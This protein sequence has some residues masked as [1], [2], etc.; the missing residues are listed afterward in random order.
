MFESNVPRFTSPSISLVRWMV[1]LRPIT[2]KTV[3]QDKPEWSVEIKFLLRWPKHLFPVGLKSMI[4]FFTFCKEKL[5]IEI[6]EAN[7]HSCR[8][9]NK[10]GMTCKLQWADW[11]FCSL[12]RQFLFVCTSLFLPFYLLEPGQHLFSHGER[13]VSSVVGNRVEREGFWCDTEMGT[14]CKH[15]KR[16]FPPGKSGLV[17]TGCQNIFKRGVLLALV[18]LL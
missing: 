1:K 9:L 10:R 5:W 6:T 16:P 12:P 18:C 11:G 17:K 3:P 7:T 2:S 13:L 8:V 15:G 4:F 14:K